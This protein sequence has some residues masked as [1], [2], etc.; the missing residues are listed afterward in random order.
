MRCGLGA[1]VAVFEATPEVPE[2]RGDGGDL[3]IMDKI[4]CVLRGEQVCVVRPGVCLIA[5]QR[6]AK[7]RT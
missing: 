6:F 5:R 4:A 7:Q 1:I 2:A 3:E